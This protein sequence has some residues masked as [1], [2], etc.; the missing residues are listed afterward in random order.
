[1]LAPCAFSCPEHAAPSACSNGRFTVQP[2]GDFWPDRRA[3]FTEAWC[4]LVTR[5]WCYLAAN[6]S[7]HVDQI[8]HSIYITNLRRARRG[9][10]LSQAFEFFLP[11][12]H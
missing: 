4:F 8:T 9:I 7:I 12:R 11:E 1:M 3:G 10:H 2:Y 5:I 6:I